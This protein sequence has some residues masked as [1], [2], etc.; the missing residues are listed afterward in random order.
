VAESQRAIE[1]F[2]RVLAESHVEA[3]DIQRERERLARELEREARRQQELRQ[4]EGRE[5]R[6][7]EA[8][9]Y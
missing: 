6:E 5:Q 2:E 8:P 4:R 1:D 3:P 7:R 9:F